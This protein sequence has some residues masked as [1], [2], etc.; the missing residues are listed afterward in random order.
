MSMGKKT[1]NRAA[2]MGFA[3]TTASS[4]EIIKR[5]SNIAIYNTETGWSERQD[6]FSKHGGRA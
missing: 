6:V 1:I 4:Q 5:L 3:K 2:G